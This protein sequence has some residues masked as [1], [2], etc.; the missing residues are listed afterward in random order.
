MTSILPNLSGITSPCSLE[1]PKAIS[2]FQML[3]SRAGLD[4]SDRLDLAV[5]L[6][7]HIFSALTGTKACREGLLQDHHHSGGN[8]SQCLTYFP[9]FACLFDHERQHDMIKGLNALFDP[10]SKLGIIKPEGYLQMTGDPSAMGC[11]LP[12]IVD[13]NGA[14]VIKPT[15]F[16]G[17]FGR[18]QF[19]IKLEHHLQTSAS[20]ES[21]LNALETTSLVDRIAAESLLHNSVKFYRPKYLAQVEESVLA[22]S[23]AVSS[24]RTCISG[25]LS[26]APADGFIKGIVASVDSTPEQSRAIIFDQIRSLA[27]DQLK[28][29]DSEVGIQYA[30]RNLKLLFKNLAPYGFDPFEQLDRMGAFETLAPVDLVTATVEQG[31]KTHSRQVKG[32]MLSWLDAS[33]STLN[34]DEVLAKNPSTQMIGYLYKVSEDARYRS[35]LLRS[36]QGR[37][38]VF[39]ADMGL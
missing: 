22:Q 9:V 23:R 36:D 4:I 24:I 3:S 15:E 29:R 18:L 20:L 38:G 8:V 37:D 28:V 5:M 19:M 14:L 21:L 25:C 13:E 30:T 2:Q 34:V 10:F 39:A 11:E 6:S 17:V 35:Y 12:S 1:I 32:K 27:G 31:I 7:D 26:P 33:L 16:I